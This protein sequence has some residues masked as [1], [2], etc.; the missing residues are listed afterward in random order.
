MKIISGIAFGLI[1]T[2]SFTYCSNRQGDRSAENAIQPNTENIDR[3]KYILDT[4]NSVIT[5]IGSKPTGQHNGTINID[6][7][8]IYVSENDIISGQFYIDI[9][10]IDIKDLK[11]QPEKFDKLKKHLISEDFFAAD[12]FPKGIFEISQV[13]PFDS[14]L[15]TNNKEEFESEYTPASNREFIVNNP[16]HFVHGNLELKGITRSIKF[17]AI[18]TLK[19]NVLKAEGK[20]NIDRTRW[21]ISY[22]DESS[23]LDKLKD[24]FIY[25]TVNVGFSIEATFQE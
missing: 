14:S 18:I 5:W 22:Q 16:T 21:N 9:K 7:G 11:K 17:P 19:N 15:Q 25:N 23:V 10:S 13:I 12:S 2:L 20:F 1:I 3:E 6:S 8:T 4:L 24:Q